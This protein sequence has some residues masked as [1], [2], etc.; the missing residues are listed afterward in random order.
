M[1]NEEGVGTLVKRNLYLDRIRPEAEW[2]AF[3]EAFK[4][5]EGQLK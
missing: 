2:D 4:I 5:R 1:N 3:Y